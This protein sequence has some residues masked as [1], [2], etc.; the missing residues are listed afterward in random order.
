MPTRGPWLSARAFARLAQTAAL[1]C[2]YGRD[3]ADG[4]AF[5]LL[6][7]ARRTRR[8]MRFRQSQSRIA[9]LPVR[10]TQLCP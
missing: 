7:S 6:P 1:A 5:H 4:S 9:I 2:W 3:M 10:N 8:M